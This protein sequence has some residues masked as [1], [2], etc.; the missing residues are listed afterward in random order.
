MK[1]KIQHWPGFPH[2]RADSPFLNPTPATSP[3]PSPSRRTLPSTSPNRTSNS[4]Q[5]PL[6]KP[7]PRTSI[8]GDCTSAVTGEESAVG[9]TMSAVNVWITVLSR[10]SC[11]VSVH[12]SLLR[13]RTHAVL[14][15][16]TA[17]SPSRL[18]TTTLFKYEAGCT[19]CVAVKSEGMS[20]TA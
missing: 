3:H 20:R 4:A 8:A 15:F 13:F 11:D 9:E 2:A 16:Q 14:T 6:A 10:E 17:N 12:Q 19:I 18:A 5:I 7:T 1:N